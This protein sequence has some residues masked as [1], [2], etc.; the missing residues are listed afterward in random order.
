MCKLCSLPFTSRKNS[1]LSDMFVSFVGA[2]YFNS[3]LL[4]SLF[5]HPSIRLRDRSI[6]LFHRLHRLVSC[7]YGWGRDHAFVECYVSPI[8][9]LRRQSRECRVY[10]CGVLLCCRYSNKGE[11]K[12]REKG[13]TDNT[14]EMK[15]KDYD[16]DWFFFHD[17][18]Q[19]DPF[20]H[21]LPPTSS[22]QTK[23]NQK[24]GHSA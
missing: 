8:L 15:T 6:S 22:M 3:W 4:P 20:Y 12:K 5:I 16:I 18:T 14:N 23:L 11:S 9:L 21:S 17:T 2:I 1:F 19:K 13:V 7:L 24:D 10:P